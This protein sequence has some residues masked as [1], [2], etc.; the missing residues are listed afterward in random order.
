MWNGL[1]LR[2]PTRCWWVVPLHRRAV[3]SRWCGG[4]RQWR[5]VVVEAK[6]C[7][8]TRP[9]DAEWAAGLGADRIGVVFAWGPRVVSPELAR[10]IVF[11]AGQVPVIG[12]VG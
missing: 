8:V 2:A 5:V 11:A 9:E 6:I 7:G 4:L 10:E 1:R 3:R 12:V